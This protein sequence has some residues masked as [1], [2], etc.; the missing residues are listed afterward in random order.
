MNKLFV[1]LLISISTFGSIAQYDLLESYGEIFSFGAEIS[2]TNG[3]FNYKSNQGNFQ[4]YDT[5]LN[6]TYLLFSPAVY[7]HIPIYLESDK[8]MI[9]ANINF[10]FNFK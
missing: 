1:T 3:E 6:Y 7:V 4:E 8:H 5:T 9:Y 2:R 10:L